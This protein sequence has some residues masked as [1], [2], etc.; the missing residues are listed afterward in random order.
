MSNDNAETDSSMF[1]YSRHIRH[2]HA[3]GG[4][5][6]T[7]PGLG[8]ALQRL[9]DGPRGHHPPRPSPLSPLLGQHQPARPPPGARQPPVGQSVSG[10]GHQLQVRQ[11]TLPQDPGAAQV[12][13][14]E[15]PLP[16]R[17]Q[18]GRGPAG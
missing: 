5:P 16:V 18:G 7:Q 3:R 8:S 12:Q 6:H 14:P 10:D 17:G 2:L 11:E 15:V 13:H 9:A 4:D 1:Q